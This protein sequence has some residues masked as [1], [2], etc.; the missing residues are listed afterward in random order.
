MSELV[1]CRAHPLAGL[2]PAAGPAAPS[3]RVVGA[4]NGD[5]G[6]A[7]AAANP[8]TSCDSHSECTDTRSRNSRASTVAVPESVEQLLHE[9]SVK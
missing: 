6:H 2:V 5:P 3:S 4:T 9:F 8:G 1:R 7:S